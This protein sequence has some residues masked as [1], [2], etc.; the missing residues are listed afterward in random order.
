MAEA[1]T[2]RLPALGSA[3]TYKLAAVIL[4]FA[5]MLSF[6]KDVAQMLS[7]L[8]GHAASILRDAWR[9]EA[10]MLAPA[11]ATQIPAT[12]AQILVRMRHGPLRM[13]DLSVESIYNGPTLYMV[14][15]PAVTT[16]L[17]TFSSKVADLFRAHCY[18]Q[19]PYF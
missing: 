15:Y 2:L 11:A 8:E 4:V 18:G 5:L 1:Q 10:A 17:S 19:N 6:G 16:G 3:A 7:S 13:R 9:D 12:G 14:A